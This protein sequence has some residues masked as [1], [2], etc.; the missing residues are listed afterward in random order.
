MKMNLYTLL[1]V[2]L[3]VCGC[4]SEPAMYRS[5]DLTQ[6]LILKESEYLIRGTANGRSAT[7]LTAD[8][9]AKFVVNGISDVPPTGYV[10]VLWKSGSHWRIAKSFSA[11]IPPSAEKE[12]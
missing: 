12:E 10:C 1:F 11:P 3:M 4:Q 6:T 5:R 9:G 8:N 2:G 7:I